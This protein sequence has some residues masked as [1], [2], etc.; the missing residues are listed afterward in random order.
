[1]RASVTDRAR[2]LWN[3]YQF[4]SHDVGARVAKV[5]RRAHAAD[6]RIA[7]RLG[8][9]VEKQRVLDIGPGQQLPYLSYFA[10]HNDAV[11]VDLDLIADHVT[12]RRYVEMFRR[13]GPVRVAKTFGRHALGLHRRYR[14]EL[15][16]QLGARELS[17]HALVQADASRLGFRTGAIDVVFSNSEFEH[18]ETPELVMRDAARV[19]RGGGVAYISVHPWTSEAGCHDPRIFAGRRDALP[20]W[21]HLR[22]DY[23]DL[24]RSNAY[25]NRWSIDR[26]RETFERE[27]PGATVE[28]HLDEELRPE[29]DRV[30]GSGE[31]GA[32]R[33]EELLVTDLVAI[34]QKP[35][36]PPTAQQTHG[37]G[38]A[39]APSP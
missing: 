26:W 36:D 17:G 20:M 31:L 33:D 10:R 4:H 39:S 21:S 8:V 11:G 13:N 9:P 23:A 3:L 28:V 16:R 12:A 25:L 5:V 22:D 14:A 24:V 35:G 6:A 1:M 7:E 32:F 18:L 29:L 27:W 37:K 15:A 34:W 19:L 30:R 38:K 2:E